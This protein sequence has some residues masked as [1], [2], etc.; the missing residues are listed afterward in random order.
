MA[1]NHTTSKKLTD[2]MCLLPIGDDYFHEFY[3][4]DFFGPDV[5][6]ELTNIPDEL[7][8]LTQSSQFGPSLLVRHKG[9]IIWP[10]QISKHKPEGSDHR[11]CEFTQVRKQLAAIMATHV[12]AESDYYSLLRS[13]LAVQ[14]MASGLSAADAENE[15]EHQ[16]LGL[17]D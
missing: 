8:S 10:D 16:C 13:C 3:Y 12:Q 6:T 17:G 15:R 1:A 11:P 9:N 2:I 14:G 5:A 4:G 7:K